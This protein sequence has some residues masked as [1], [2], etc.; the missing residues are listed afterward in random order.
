MRPSRW[1]S[2]RSAEP[3]QCQFGWHI[4][5]LDEKRKSAPPTLDQVGPQL[6]Q[7]VLFKNFDDTVG[8][9]KAGLTDR[10]PG[11]GP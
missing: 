4:I 9:L 1:K 7:Q 2:G 5:K 10:H 11:R 6:Q 8:A 3:V